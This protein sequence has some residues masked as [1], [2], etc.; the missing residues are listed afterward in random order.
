MIEWSRGTGFKKYKA[1]IY[2]RGKKVKY[3]FD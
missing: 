3:K 1:V 2:L